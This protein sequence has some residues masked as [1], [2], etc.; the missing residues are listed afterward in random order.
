MTAP[1]L[2]ICIPVY[3]FGA[4]LGATLDSI[5]PQLGE[6]VEVLVLDG[7]S[8]D[9]TAAVMARAMEGCPGLRYDRRPV[10]GG[11][12]RDMALAVA[13]ARG[14]YCWIFSG[15]D[16]MR[17]GA[18]ARV[19]GEL[20]S[21]CDVYLLESMRCDFELRPLALHRLA[22][23]DAPRTFRLH[24]PAERREYFALALN[25]AAFFSF[26]SALVFRRARWDEAPPDESFYGSCW[27]HAAR[28]FS[29]LPGGLTVRYLPGAIL[30][31][32]GDNDSFNT[33][34]L[35]H[36]YGIAVDGYHRI[37]DTFF[38][39]DSLEAFHL[40]RAVR[41]EQPWAGWLAAKAE[42]VATGRLEHWPLFDRLVRAQYGDAG[43]AC[44]AARTSLRLAPA[45]VLV[46]LRRG[47]HA[48][49]GRRAPR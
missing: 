9:D 7:G 46:W 31:K 18:V 17:P 32:R 6:A 35:T 5:L 45:R 24:D 30:D 41:A 3:N 42:L 27:A 10:R 25:T 13:Q 22:R 29:L 43:L 11:I 4:F 19:L 33:Q 49:R 20:G 26:C 34:G 37:G 1:R 21:G 2:T 44:W 15:D 36:R 39:H 14:D 16:L 28:L 48:W 8:T 40:R 12:D 23:L 38:G 47:V